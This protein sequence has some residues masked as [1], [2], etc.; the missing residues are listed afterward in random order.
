[1]K[2]ITLCFVV[3][4]ENQFELINLALIARIVKINGIPYIGMAGQNFT[5]Q[6]T[7]NSYTELLD[8]IEYV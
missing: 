4:G 2:A 1:M 5:R 6:I 7:N 3:K 8:T